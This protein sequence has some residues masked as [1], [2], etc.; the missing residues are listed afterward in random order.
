MIIL[1]VYGRIERRHLPLITLLLV[2]VNCVVFW[3]PQ[4]DDAEA[5]QGALAFYLAANLG[6]IEMPLYRDY[7]A[8]RTAAPPSVRAAGAAEAE[9][10]SDPDLVFEAYSH[11]DFVAELPARVAAAVPAETYAQW[12][13]QHAEFTARL[14]KV[15]WFTYGLR[16]AYATPTTLLTHMFLHGGMDHLLGNMVFLVLVGYVVEL[17]LGG[18]TFFVCYLAAGLIAGGFDLLFNGASITTGI[19][20]SGAISGVMGMYVMLFGWR[21]INF[22]YHVLF[23]FNYVK[24]P[25]LVVLP[26]WIGYQVLEMFLDSASH[27]NYLAHAGGLCGGAL[28]GMLFKSRLGGANREVLDA[29]ANRERREAGDVDIARLLAD[30]KYEKAAAAIL[31]QPEWFTRPNLFSQLAAAMRNIDNVIIGRKILAA[32]LNVAVRD[33]HAVK[34]KQVIF[35]AFVEKYGALPREVMPRL[36]QIALQFAAA[37]H[38]DDAESIVELLLG[39]GVKDVS[40]AEAIYRMALQQRTVGDSEGYDRNCSRLRQ[41]FPASPLLTALARVS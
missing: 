18:L 11:G 25:A 19:G 8:Q 10:A 13:G 12:Q 26:V 30:M 7:L 4:R 15:T 17:I 36:G 22:F 39:A 2:I 20:A 6:A 32:A 41:Y 35:S 16:P 23:Y 37:G 24:L 28:I 9:R 27:I 5:L 40:L 33:R 38:T 21:R 29:H 1:P 31:R 34:Q 3:G 14:A